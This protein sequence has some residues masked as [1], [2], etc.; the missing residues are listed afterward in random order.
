MVPGAGLGSLILD[1]EGLLART[2]RCTTNGEEEGNGGGGG[3]RGVVTLEGAGLP[4]LSA[5]KF[6]FPRII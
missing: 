5:I 2:T 4:C 1:T 3:A 6:R